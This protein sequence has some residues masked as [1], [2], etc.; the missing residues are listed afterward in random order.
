MLGSH[1]VR[2]LGKRNGLIGGE[3]KKYWN[4]LNN[5]KVNPTAKTQTLPIVCTH[6]EGFPTNHM[7]MLQTS[8]VSSGRQ[9]GAEGRSFRALASCHL[10]QGER[11]VGSRFHAWVGTMRLTAPGKYFCFCLETRNMIWHH[12]MTFPAARVFYGT[13]NKLD[14]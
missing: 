3:W 4:H 8:A 13:Y 11:P 12:L 1:P 10:I 14:V 6:P 9:V 5:A 2:I 7:W